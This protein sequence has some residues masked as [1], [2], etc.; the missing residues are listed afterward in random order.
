MMLCM[1]NFDEILYVRFLVL[2]AASMKMVV[3]WVV[4][5]CSLVD[6]LVMHADSIIRAMI[7]YKRLTDCTAQQP[8]RQPS[9]I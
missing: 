7:V 6:V 2:A 4:A 8:R 3:F 9:S 1:S 5:P